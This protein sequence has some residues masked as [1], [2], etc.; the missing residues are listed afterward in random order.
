M[1]RARAG[2]DEH[3]LIDHRRQPVG[4][5]VKRVGNL[6]AATVTPPHGNGSFWSTS[7]PLEAWVLIQKLRDE[8]G[9]HTTDITDALYDE[10]PFWSNRSHTSD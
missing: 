3:P 10:D 1:L 2:I 4:I 8:V 7:E 9:C 6:F 5:N